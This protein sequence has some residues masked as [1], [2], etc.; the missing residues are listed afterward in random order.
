MVGTQKATMK[1][2]RAN[3]TGKAQ[4]VQFVCFYSHHRQNRA[5]SKSKREQTE[6]LAS[7]DISLV[8][9]LVS[10]FPSLFYLLT[11]QTPVCRKA[12]IVRPKMV[13]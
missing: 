9:C 2:L 7:R 6:F 3:F 10:R 13:F 11:L 4:T 12:R 8:F 5:A 1:K